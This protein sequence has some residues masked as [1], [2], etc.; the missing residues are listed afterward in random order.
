MVAVTDHFF[1]C[2]VSGLDCFSRIISFTSL[3]SREGVCVGTHLLCSASVCSV[4]NQVVYL[5]L[6]QTKEQ[7][8]AQKN[9]QKCKKEL[10]DAQEELKVR[11]E[12][13]S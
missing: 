13:L 11:C 1:V 9:I 12:V 8:D 10:A 4:P 3:R 2:A 7:Q 6:S 5:S